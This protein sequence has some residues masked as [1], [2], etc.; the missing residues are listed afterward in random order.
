MVVRSVRTHKRY[1]NRKVMDRYMPNFKFFTFVHFLYVGRFG[2]Q[3]DHFLGALNFAKHLDRTLILPPWVEYRPGQL[4]S[5]SQIINS[6]DWA[7]INIDKYI[8][9][10]HLPRGSKL[11]WRKDMGG[12]LPSTRNNKIT[13]QQCLTHT[14]DTV[15]RWVATI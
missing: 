15:I 14:L 8:F 5:V 2:N 12:G 1:D 10:C 7:N 13:D 6:I 11:R 9:A 4:K 3:A